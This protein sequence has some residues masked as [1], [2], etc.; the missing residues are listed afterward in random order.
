MNRIARAFTVAALGAIAAAA[1]PAFAETKAPAQPVDASAQ[2][3]D[4]TK[5]CIMASNTGSR[6]KRKVCATRAEWIEREGYDPL[7][8][9]K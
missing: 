9:I 1:T 6:I 3:S 5:Y 4:D 7:T 8:D 2:A